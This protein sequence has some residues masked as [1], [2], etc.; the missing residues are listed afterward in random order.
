MGVVGE[1][2]EHFRFVL[3]EELYNGLGFFRP[4]DLEH[5][6]GSLDLEASIPGVT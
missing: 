2:G 5:F 4:A 1:C 6:T 3:G